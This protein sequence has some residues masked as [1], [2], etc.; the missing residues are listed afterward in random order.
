MEKRQFPAPAIYDSSD[1][2][3]SADPNA[4]MH[5]PGSGITKNLYELC[6]EKDLPFVAM[7]MF[8]SDGDNFAEAVKFFQMADNVFEFR[9]ARVTEANK[10]ELGR[11]HWPPSWYPF[12][13][14][15]ENAP[16]LLY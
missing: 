1:E 2:D 4:I 5:L 7:I 14:E 6:T 16:P 9:K 3:S 11:P 12:I 8:A 10:G 15:A 13:V